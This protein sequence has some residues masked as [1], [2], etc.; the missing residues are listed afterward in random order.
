LLAAADNVAKETVARMNAVERS[1]R[2]T[3]FRS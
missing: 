2:T 1:V 3:E